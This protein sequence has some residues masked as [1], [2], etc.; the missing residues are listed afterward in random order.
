MQFIVGEEVN[1]PEYTGAQKCVV[2]EVGND[3]WRIG[4]CQV[5]VTLHTGEC[6]EL[7]LRDSLLKKIKRTPEVGTGNKLNIEMKI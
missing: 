7:W 6:R 3:G 4:H 1:I 5:R 2:T